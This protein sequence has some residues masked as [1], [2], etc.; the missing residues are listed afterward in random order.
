MKKLGLVL[1]LIGVTCLFYACTT[2]GIEEEVIVDINE[3]KQKYS[4]TNRL[5]DEKSPY[6]LQHAHNPVDW[7]PWGD[8]AFEKAVQENKPIFLSI[9]YSTCHWC[10]VMEEESFENVEVAAHLNENFIAI[11]VDREERP[12]IDSYY[13]TV[14]QLLTG[15]GGWPLNVILTPDKKPFFAGT[16]IPRESFP[17]RTGMLT[18]LPAISDAWENRKGEVDSSVESIMNALEQTITADLSGNGITD[19]FHATAFEHLSSAFDSVNGGFGQSPKFPAAHNLIFLTR[20]WKR[21][22]EISAL[23]MIEKTLVEMRYGGI[24]DHVGFGFHRYS[25][26]SE[27]HL[28]HFEKMLYDQAMISAAYIEA[29]QATDNE[30]FRQTVEEIFSYELR[31]MSS[32]EGGFYTAEDADSEGEEGIFYLWSMKELELL[33]GDNAPAIS[34]AFGASVEGNY[35]D[36]ASGTATSLNLLDRVGDVVPLEWDEARIEL[37]AVRDKRIH[38][39]KDD[40]ILTDWNGLMISSLARGSRVFGNDTYV[41]AARNAADFIVYEMTLEDGSLLHMYREGEASIEGNLDDYAFFIQGLI[42]LYQATFDL[43]YLEKA[44][45][46]TEKMLEDFLDDDEGGFYLTSDGNDE[47]PIRQKKSADGALPS[48]NSAAFGNFLRLSWLTGNTEYLNHGLNIGKN[49]SRFLKQAP[50]GHSMMLAWHEL[51]LAE[52]VE[53]IVVGNKKAEDT[54]NILSE[55]DKL[56]VPGMVILVKDS[57]TGDSALEKI[58]PFTEGYGII[59]GKATVYV[60]R[61]FVCNL[62]TN[63]IEEMLSQIVTSR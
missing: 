13:M 50:E 4:F 15:G 46:L 3:E 32:P 17:G 18:L 47:L 48:A 16:Y 23:E 41:Q 45:S 1:K 33:L 63:D 53:V 60:C 61:N 44:V 34:A 12:D 57:E 20:Y 38:P 7:Y 24:Y 26:D 29:Y 11:K 19:A 62:P 49:F 56:Y 8:E 22:G 14:A 37:L 28:P 31:E 30:L 21:T 59:G 2:Q 54:K 39:L 36:E 40:K 43:K 6:L 52:P 5:V 25:T 9:G 35:R 10:H 27:W 55:L 58:A 42:D 51:L